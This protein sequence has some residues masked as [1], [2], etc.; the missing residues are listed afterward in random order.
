MEPLNLLFLVGSLVFILISFSIGIFVIFH[1]QPLTDHEI[2]QLANKRRQKKIRQYFSFERHE[3]NV[4]T[5]FKKRMNPSG[6]FHSVNESLIKFPAI[7]AGL[8]KYKKHEW[9]IVAFERNMKINKLWINKGISRSRAYI[10]ISAGYTSSIAKADG[11]FSVLIFHNHPNRDPTHYDCT[12][13]SNQDII[14]AKAYAQV[15][16]GEGKNLLEFVCER[17]RHFQYFQSICNDFLRLS[18]FTSAI[19]KINGISSLNN[20]KL[21]LERIF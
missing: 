8:L 7:A 6:E 18:E 14:S 4:N 11:D 17:G 1:I 5:E 20:I 19:K 13:P 15:L 10:H 2:I 3:F 9:I 16:N 21:H 12:R